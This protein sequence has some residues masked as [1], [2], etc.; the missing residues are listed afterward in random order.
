MIHVSDTRTLNVA[1][2]LPNKGGQQCS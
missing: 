2:R 1:A